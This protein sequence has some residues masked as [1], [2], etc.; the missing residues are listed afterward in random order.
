MMSERYWIIWDIKTEMFAL[1]DEEKG[2]FILYSPDE[3]LLYSLLLLPIFS[4]E[5]LSERIVSE[6]E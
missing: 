3:D 6:D 5:E 2:G 4:N 1:C